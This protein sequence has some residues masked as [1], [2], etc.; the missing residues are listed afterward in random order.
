MCVCVLFAPV[1]AIKAVALAYVGNMDEVPV[2]STTPASSDA[3]SVIVNCD[4]VSVTKMQA[5]TAVFNML[6]DWYE[7]MKGQKK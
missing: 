7:S 2:K 5:M 4:A 6:Q 1:H 3:K